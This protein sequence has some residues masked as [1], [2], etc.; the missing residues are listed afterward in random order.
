MSQLLIFL[1][2]S[3]LRRVFAPQDRAVIK[4]LMVLEWKRGSTAESA[5]K[6]E[7]AREAYPPE[8]R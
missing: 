5:E 3:S 4:I 7:G 8:L 2:F 1:F 6:A